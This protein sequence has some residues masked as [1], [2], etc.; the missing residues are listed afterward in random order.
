MTAF[1][2]LEAQGD[3]REL[4]GDWLIGPFRHIRTICKLQH[5][6]FTLAM[7]QQQAAIPQAPMF[8]FHDP[9]N[10]GSYAP[11]RIGTPI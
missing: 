5:T 2:P 6:E 11:V 7:S 1:F 4:V 3:A 8:N 9:S 10:C